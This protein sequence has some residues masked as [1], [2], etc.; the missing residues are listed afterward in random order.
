MRRREAVVGD[1]GGDGPEEQEKAALRE[2]LVVP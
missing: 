2:T 1:G